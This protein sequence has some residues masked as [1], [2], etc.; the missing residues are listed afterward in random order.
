ML[1]RMR[2]NPQSDWQ[3]GDIETLCENV[4]LNLTPPSR[5][6][7]YKISSDLIPMTVLTIPYNR[8]IKAPYIK[9]FVKLIDAHIE[10]CV[11]GGER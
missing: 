6:S 1:A 5:G 7:H 8:P 2:D 9:Q 3:I 4:G 10:H 11:K